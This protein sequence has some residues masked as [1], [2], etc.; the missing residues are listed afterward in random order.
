VAGVRVDIAVSVAIPFVRQRGAS[1][2][3]GKAAAAIGGSSGERFLAI[4]HHCM[5]LRVAHQ[6]DDGLRVRAISGKVAGAHNIAGWHG[7]AACFGQD[8]LGS[9]QIA[10]GAAEDQQGSGGFDYLRRVGH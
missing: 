3:F 1:A 5:D 4:A 10:V 2:I 8:R 9:L 7:T 6:I